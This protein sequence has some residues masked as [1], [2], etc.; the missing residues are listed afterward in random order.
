MPRTAAAND[1]IKDRRRSKILEKSLK[2]FALKGFDRVTVDDITEASNCS[3]GLFYHYF[4][5]KED[6]YNA[7]IKLKE[8]KF[9]EYS[10]PEKAAMAAGGIKGLEILADYCE[11]VVSGP[12]DV[13]YFL[14]LS[15][16]RHYAATCYNEDLL[17]VDVFP[18]LVELIK[19]GQAEGTVRA[20]NPNEIADMFIDFANG[21]IYRRLFE[22]IERYCIVRKESILRIFAK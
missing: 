10:I 16:T 13:L 17:G 8:E 12:E 20:G 6:V 5:G 7:L 1:A 22:G 15:S 18:D 14:R 21:S 3:H 4:R 11:K 19:E 9:S 2:L